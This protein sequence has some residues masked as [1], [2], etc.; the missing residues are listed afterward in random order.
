MTARFRGGRSAFPIPCFT[1]ALPILATAVFSAAVAA[2][3]GE[4]GEASRPVGQKV[5]GQVNDLIQFRQP[6]GRT[7]ELRAGA[8]RVLP[9]MTSLVAAWYLAGGTAVGRPSGSDV[10]ALPLEARELPAVG[11][12]SSPNPETIFA[13]KPDLVILVDKAEKQAALAEMLR[14]AGIPTV[15]VR[16]DNY[17]DFREV[18]DLFCRL[19][20]RR[21]DEYPP[22]RELEYQVRAVRA[23][24]MARP[25]AR[26]RAP[27]FISLFASG[28]GVS[29]ETDRANTPTM[30]RHLG[31]VNVVR[32]DEGLRRK[33]SL[34]RLIV[35]DPDVILIVAMGD[36]DATRAAF[37]KNWSG[38]PAWQ[39]LSA[40]KNKRVHVLPREWFLYVPGP[41]F[42]D[43]FRHLAPLLPSMPIDP[44]RRPPA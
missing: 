43:A 39:Q 29:A 19:N 3:A 9:C 15:T 28:L 23:Q 4:S 40:V 34:E 12:H 24:S 42:P 32:T 2:V 6:D 31:A 37:E 41:A 27:R 8:E 17:D 16:Y 18:M 22:M 11:R 20:G 25:R 5:L 26:P 30:A 35:E 44:R 36:P 14:P 38:H 7:V 10:D 1:G 21:A 13:L 33:Y